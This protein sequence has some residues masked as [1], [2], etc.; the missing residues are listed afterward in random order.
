MRTWVESL[1][2]LSGLRIQHCHKLWFRSQTQ[3][4]SGIAVLVEQASGY[5]SDWTSS[6]G[7]S[8]CFRCR[9][10]KTKRKK[11]RKKEALK[12]PL[13]HSGLRI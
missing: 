10:K 5:S 7:T 4:G 13:W 2:W 9:L 12:F 11:E 6:L 1:A 8:I 3:F